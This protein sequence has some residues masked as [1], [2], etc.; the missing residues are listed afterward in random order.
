MKT[1]TPTTFSSID[2]DLLTDVQGGCGGRGCC[3]K[4]RC[5]QQVNVTNNYAAA[6]AAAPARSGSSVD[7]SVG[8]PQ[9]WF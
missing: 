7:V 6:P 1:N 9:P 4:R 3:R 2:T 8:S 5:S